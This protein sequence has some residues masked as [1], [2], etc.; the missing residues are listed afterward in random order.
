MEVMSKFFNLNNVINLDELITEFSMNDGK[1]LKIVMDNMMKIEEDFV[2]EL[3][4]K[5]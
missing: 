1:T 3:K 2:K 4:V 5:K